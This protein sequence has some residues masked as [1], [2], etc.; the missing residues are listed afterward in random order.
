M[1]VSE[2]PRPIEVLSDKEYQRLFGYKADYVKGRTSFYDSFL[3]SSK[4]VPRKSRIG[5]ILTLDE[6]NTSF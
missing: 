2:I 6:I 1:R 4:A 3:D 5:S